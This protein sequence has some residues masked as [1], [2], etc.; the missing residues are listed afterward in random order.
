VPTFGELGYP[1][2]LVGVW[3]G[4]MAPAGTPKEIV[5]VLNREIVASL[6]A[7]ELK[8][9]LD[10]MDAYTVGGPPERFGAFLDAEITRWGRVVKASK[11]VQD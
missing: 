8:A 6:Q 3:W 1:D 7:P 11:A 10:A 2:Y 4:I 5:A 9:R